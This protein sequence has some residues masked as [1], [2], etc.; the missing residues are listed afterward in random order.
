MSEAELTA[1]ALAGEGLLVA[2]RPVVVLLSG[3]RDSTCLLDLAIATCGRDYV[4]A[5]HLNYG[6]R[7]AADADERHCIEL[8]S[9]L[10]VGIEV[11]RPRRPERG[12][13]Q[14]WARDAR[15]GA[16]AKLARGRGADVAAGHTATD[17]VE[18]ILY[19]LASSPSRR[20]LLGMR[21][22]E[23]ILVRPLLR[24]TRAQTAEYCRGR[25]LQW[26]EDESNRSAEFARGRIRANLVPALREVHPAAEENVLA[27]AELLRDEAAV[28]DELVDG[29]LGGREEIELA[30]LRTL[31]PALRRLVVQRLADRAAGGFA[32]GV[33][34]RAD[35]VAELPLVGESALDLPHVRA[36]VSRGRLRF[37]RRTASA[38]QRE[39]HTKSARSAPIN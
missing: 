24:F 36:A 14:A 13:L 11:G 29:V 31:A 6:L 20:A 7:D 30:M 23:G 9:R 28:L 25:G 18:T 21:P 10:G 4:T 12:N 26:R 38:G 37:A 19:R 16:A 34:R 35:E 15:Y 5:L 17:Q 33:A 39:T 27:L 22:R 1:T 3:G 32:P 8:C 2:S